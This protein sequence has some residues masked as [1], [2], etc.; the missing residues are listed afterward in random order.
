MLVIGAAGLETAEFDRE[1]GV[2]LGDTRAQLE[3]INELE[4]DW[5]GRLVGKIVDQGDIRSWHLEKHLFELPLRTLVALE[6]F[7]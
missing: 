6:A 2:P 5:E 3:F 4:V 1:P 7:Q